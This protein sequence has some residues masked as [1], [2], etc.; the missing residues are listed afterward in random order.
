MAKQVGPEGIRAREA[1][2]RA[3]IFLRQ[4]FRR[5]DSATQQAVIDTL[6]EMQTLIDTGDTRQA[7]EHFFRRMQER[8]REDV[9]WEEVRW[10][11]HESCFGHNLNDYE[12]DE[13]LPNRVG[14]QL[15]VFEA[16]TEMPLRFDELF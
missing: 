15:T 6:K 11:I 13:L 5:Y 16:L 9:D 10:Q 8:K 1:E 14:S 2:Q 3:G 12:P 7:E 4:E